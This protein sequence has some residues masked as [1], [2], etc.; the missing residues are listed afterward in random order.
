MKIRVLGCSGGIG[1]PQMHTTAFLLDRDILIDAGTGVGR[2]SIDELMAIDHVFLTHSHL[3]HVAALA[4]LLDAVG[5][6]REQP[7]IVHA[8]QATIE[9]LRAHVFNWTIWPDFTQIPSADNPFLRFSPI[10]VGRPTVIDG[11]QITPLPANH[12][13][14]AVAY[15]LDSGAGSLVFSGDTGP[16]P[17][18]WAAVNQIDNL[19]YLLIECAFPDGEKRLAETSLHLCPSLLSEQL[20]LLRRAAEI[21][22]THLKPGQGETTM[23]EI[24][25]G[26]AG[27]P[28]SMLQEGQVFEL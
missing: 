7:I 2:L 20:A 19:R 11:R 15:R 28:P 17:D 26:M 14:P 9:I 18:F 8:T 27:R 24:R 6:V 1:V 21:H 10:H 16:C 22:I 12:T 13:V 3:D 4:F 25:A 5:D 23:R